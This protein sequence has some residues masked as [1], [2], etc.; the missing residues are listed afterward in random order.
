MSLLDIL[1]ERI[2]QN[3]PISV[4]EYMEAALADPEFG[5]YKGKDPLGRGGDFTTSP[6]ISQMFGEVLGLW[7]AVAWD[8]M[9][10]PATINFVEIGPGR[11]TLMHDMV[12][13]ANTLP[14]FRESL[15]IH[16]VE[17]SPVLRERQESALAHLDQSVAW[18]DTIDSLP[19]GPLIV[20][21]NEFFDALPIRQFIRLGP[22]WHERQVDIGGE[23]LCFTNEP[24]PAPPV[25]LS[26]KAN[27]PATTGDITET[28]PIGETICNTLA[29][30]LV[31]FGGAALFIDYGY[32]KPSLG[33]SLQAVK[34]HAYHP[35]LQ[36]PGEADLTAHV[37]FDAL[38]Q[39]ARRAGAKAYGVLAQGTFLRR[40]GIE[41]R[42]Q[43]LSRKATDEQRDDIAMA[44]KRL[45]HEDEMGNL[46]KVLALAHPAQPTPPGF[47]NEQP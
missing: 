47:D 26:N 39:A 10:Q 46:F 4:A 43:I 28:C 45:I 17:T 27:L 44:L 41:A 38:A 25:D 18:H 36:A 3:G 11:G 21:A 24:L 12:R 37:D 23:T 2:E 14:G 22:A 31:R 7:C 8:Q 33:D 42:A 6:E 40:L 16:L 29:A 9:G 35:V 20:V 32:G 19:D 1:K 13:A 15:V 30:R 34:G 5:Y